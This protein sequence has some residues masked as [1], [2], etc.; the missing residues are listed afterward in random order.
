MRGASRGALAARLTF[1]ASQQVSETLPAVLR[2]GLDVS[3]LALTKAGTARYLTNL[4]EG[5]ERD[6]T[7]ETRG[8][9]LGGP[10]RLTRVARDMIWY[11][12]T[13]PRAARRDRV[14]VLHCPTM[15]APVRS[16]VPLVVTIHDVAV[17]RHPETFNRWTRTYSALALPRVARAASAIV[18]GSRFAADEV[19]E[20]LE[21]PDEKIRVI[22]YGVGPPFQPDGPRADGSYVLAVSTLEPRKNLPRLVEGFRRAGLDGLE[23]RVVGAEGWGDVALDGDGVRHLKDVGDE[24][25]ARLYRGAACVAYVSLYEGFGLPVLE[26][27]AC[28]APVVAPTGRP[29]DEFAHGVAFEIDPR[30]PESIAKGLQQAVAGGAQPAG[31]RRAEAEFSWERAVQSHVD[32]YRE[33]AA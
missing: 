31:A 13:L 30:D 24:E 28:A 9:E 6:P 23:L 3:P 20:L 11:P 15:R 14:D 21:V 7:L 2:V 16:R 27:M 17:L 5:L 22:P 19:R 4:L 25:L 32:L 1:K 26:A 18:V 8:Y 29:Y 33:L 10:G 12:V